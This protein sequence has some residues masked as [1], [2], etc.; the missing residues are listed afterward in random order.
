MRVLC[1]ILGWPVSKFAK[2]AVVQGRWSEYFLS[3]ML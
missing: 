3:T 1:G 2:C